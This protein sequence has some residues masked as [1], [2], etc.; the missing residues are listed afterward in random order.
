[1]SEHDDLLDGLWP[2]TE[3]PADFAERVLDACFTPRQRARALLKPILLVSAVAALA[4]AAPLVL[5]R[6]APSSPAHA[7]VSFE[8]DLGL[9]RD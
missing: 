8:P 7:A 9:M 1:M 3:P 2:A 5:L 6:A 4:L